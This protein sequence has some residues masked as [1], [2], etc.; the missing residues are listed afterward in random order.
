MSDLLNGLPTDQNILTGDESQLVDYLF[1][2]NKYSASAIVSDIKLSIFATL[3]FILLS[4]PITD[5]LISKITIFA[6]KPTILVCIKAL[7]LGILIYLFQNIW[8]IKR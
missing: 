8:T 7:I 1:G 5:K 6:S 4:L 2:K 3:I